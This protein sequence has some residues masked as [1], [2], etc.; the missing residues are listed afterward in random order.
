ML[1]INNLIHKI[2]VK[3][4]LF[5][6]LLFV[7]L[8]FVLMVV[9]SSLF[10]RNMLRHHLR[11]DALDILLQTR[12]KIEAEFTEPQTALIAISETI[13][14]MIINGYKADEVFAIMKKLGDEMSKKPDGFTFDGLFGY[15]EA[16]DGLYMT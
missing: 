7:F 16:F 1:K 3:R 2:R 8:A 13:R 11:R 15:F 10:V 5:L 9:S 4:T 14:S 12:L 6:Q